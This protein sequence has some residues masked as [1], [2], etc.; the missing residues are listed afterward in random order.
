VL[1]RSGYPDSG[2]IVV[3]AISRDMNGDPVVFKAVSRS[4]TWLIS[5]FLGIIGGLGIMLF[6]IFYMNEALQKLAG[7][8]LKELLITLTASPIRG[9]GTGLFATLF[10]HSSSATTVLEV[11]LVSA[12]LLTFFQTMPVT[13]GAEIGST[14]TSQ[15]L[16]FRLADYAVLIAGLGFFL[17]ILSHTKKW[18][19]IAEAVF[20]FGLLFLG[21]KI[22]S[23]LLIPLRDYLP[24]VDLMKRIENPLFGIGI[25]L[26]FTAIIQSSGA[27][28][29]I[30]IALALAGVIDLKQAILLNLGA[31][32]GTCVTAVIG[33]IGRAREG[34]RVALWHL[35]HQTAGVAIIYILL[36]SATWNGRPFWTA[37][38]EKFTRMFFFTEDLARQIAMAHTL[39]AVLNAAVFFFLLPAMYKFMLYLLPAKEIERPF[40]PVFIDDNLISTPSLALEEARREIVREGEIVSDM[41]ANSL[42][43]FKCADTRFCDTVSLKDI[44]ADILRNAIVPYLTKVAQGY[45]S[46]GQSKTETAL[47]FITADFEEIGDIIDKNIVPLARK[48][49]SYEMRFSEGGWNDIVELHARVLTNLN[50]AILALRANNTELMRR[51]ADTK[52]S[53]NTLESEMRKR[54][55]GRLNAGLK[56]T[57]ETSSVHLDLIDQFKRINSHIASI[58]AVLLGEF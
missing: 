33:S 22:M 8:K 53:V 46:D 58:G 20:G 39:S 47:L 18:K 43:L 48:K 41:F 34:K 12:G 16:A 38:V 26:A 21:M 31:Q 49:L 30:V 40:G 42:E 11:S 19:S 1:F 56:E 44:R 54:H 3:T 13:M 50:D 28:A 27:T 35:F 36:F 9:I 55:V 57:L 51:V 23:D 24:F 5:I 17:M 14:V 4:R 15:L 25:G 52:A 6:G 29:G 10:S 2:E 7:Q 37:F 45:L 32:I